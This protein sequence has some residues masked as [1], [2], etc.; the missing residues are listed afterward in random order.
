MTEAQIK[1]FESMKAEDIESAA[2]EISL[3]EMKELNPRKVKEAL[4]KKLSPEDQEEYQNWSYKELTNN[5]KAL[6]ALDRGIQA[7]RNHTR[8]LWKTGLEELDKKLDGGLIGGSLVFLGAVSSLGKTSLA[9]QIGTQIAENVAVDGNDVLIFSLEMS[10]DELNAKIIS[11]YT[12]EEYRR[13]PK[14]KY[15]GELSELCC[16]A[17][18]VLLGYDGSP[19]GGLG[20]REGG[21]F[22]GVDDIGAQRYELYKAARERIRK[23]SEHLYLFIGEN[24]ISVDRVR[25][26]VNR[27]VKATGNKPFVIL[28]YLQIL[29]PSDSTEFTDKRLLTDYD[30]STLKTIARDLDVPVLA[31]SAFNRNSYLEGVSSSSFRESS[32]IEYSSDILL[33]MQY[34]GMDYRKHPMTVTRRDPKTHEYKA[35]I[36]PKTGKDKKKMVY[37]SKQDHE[38][39]VRLLI[40]RMDEWGAD[41]KE[42]PLELKVL[43]NRLSPKGKVGLR[44]LPAFN[45]FRSSDNEK[46]E[47]LIATDQHW[48]EEDDDFVE[49]ADNTEVPF[50]DEGSSASYGIRSINPI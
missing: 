22:S 31:I 48:D 16:T 4:V 37:E 6:D 24:D 28:D 21:L 33:G 23:V 40:D 41:G 50:E 1:R 30:V 35:V 34:V 42:I 14:G 27:H 11:R 17:R 7:R 13:S 43:K 8:K 12:Y 47:S 15:F 26:I 19:E 2:I 39:R 29:Q 18:D 9:L 3:D 45:Y 44:F 36:D 38:T 10:K 32:G 5:L 46:D 25:E 49:I 20:D